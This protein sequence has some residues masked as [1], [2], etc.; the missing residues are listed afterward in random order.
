MVEKRAIRG[1]GGVTRQREKTEE[2]AVCT[3]SCRLD[4]LDV[5]VCWSVTSQSQSKSG[6]MT[7]M[8]GGSCALGPSSKAA[9]SVV[10]SA[11]IAQG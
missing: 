7:E 2:V 10:L 5:W 8:W 3:K 9:D 1:V 4:L 6:R 11:L